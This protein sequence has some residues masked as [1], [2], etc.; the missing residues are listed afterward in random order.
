M[1]R[2]Y[3]LVGP[4][5]SGKSYVGRL[6]NSEFGI[7][8]LAIEEIFVKLQGT[9]V[10]TPY[11]QE[12]GYEIVEERVLEILNRGNAASFEITVFMPASKNL[13]SR[14]ELNAHIELVQVYAPPELCLERIK[15]RDSTKHIEISE[16]RIAEI[17]RLSVEQHVDSKHAQQLHP[18][19]LWYRVF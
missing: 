3:V 13:L 10:S 15:A 8:F 6:L 2:I 19:S 14:L 12:K 9:G 1:N 7:E 18:C 11:I 4:K 16:E 17:N 5:G